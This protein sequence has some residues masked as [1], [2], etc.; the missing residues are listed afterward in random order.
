M[1]KKI[2]LQE[3]EKRVFRGKLGAIFSPEKTVFRFWQPFAKKAFLRLYNAENE[4]IFSAEM[5]R[6][7]NIFEYEKL[8]NCEGFL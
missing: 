3:T 1:M 4:Q 2:D 5:H 8:G 7:N 6:K